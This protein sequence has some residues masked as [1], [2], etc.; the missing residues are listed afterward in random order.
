MK[1][2]I[3]HI[4]AIGWMAASIALFT[5]CNKF[6]QEPQGEWVDGDQNGVSGAYEADVFTLYA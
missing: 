3:Y 1:K 4:I 2:N 6:D 5:H